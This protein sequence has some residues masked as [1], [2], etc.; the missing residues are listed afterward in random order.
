M[1][2]YSNIPLSWPSIVHIFYTARVY[3]GH[4]QNNYYYRIIRAEHPIMIQS[5]CP[6]WPLKVNHRYYCYD[7][8]YRNKEPERFGNKLTPIKR[9]YIYLPKY[10]SDNDIISININTVPEIILA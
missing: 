10:I 5:E 4:W 3:P 1:R 6:I 8:L 9:D 2:I 7:I